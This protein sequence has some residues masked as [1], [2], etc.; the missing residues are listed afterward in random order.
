M[1]DGVGSTAFA[2]TDGGQLASEDGP[3]DSDKISYS[4]LNRTRSSLNLQQPYA[5]DW[6]QSYDYDNQWR[7][8]DVTSPAGTFTYNYI[9]SYNDPYTYAS[10]LVYYLAMPGGSHTDKA[11]DS[12]GRLTNSALLSG[13]TILDS[14]AYAYNGGNQRTRQVFTAGNYTD[15]GYDN[16]G[17]L[18]SAK[19]TESDTTTARLNEQFGY[20]Y[21][22]AWNLNVR[23]NNA[24]IQNFAV[25]S[26][27]ELSNSFRSGTLTV[28]GSI[29]E[30]LAPD[31][32]SYGVTNVTVNGS[33]A[34]LYAD[35]TF[36]KTGFTP[37]DG[38]NTYTAVA[39]DTTG[40]QDTDVIT[41][42]LPATNTFTYDARG[43]L[44]SDGHR[45]F[46]Y[47]D[48]NQL[49]SV[50]VSNAY[51]SEFTYDGFL[52]KR[53]LKDFGWFAGAWVET[54][55]VRFV[56]DGRLVVQERDADNL[57]HVSY[58]TGSDLSG[59]REGAGGIG[60]LLARTDNR[61][62]ALGTTDGS[63][64]YGFD[65]N[66]NVTA[67]ATTNGTVAAKYSY[68][69]FGNTLS[70]TGPLSEA[71]KYRFSTKEIHM[72]SGLLHFQY[73][74]FD[75][76]LQKWLSRDPI[77][78]RGGINLFASFK[79]DP[80]DLLDPL[81]LQPGVPPR[82]PTEECD[83]EREGMPM[84]GVVVRRPLDLGPARGGRPRSRPPSEDREPV[85]LPII[86]NNPL[87]EA[88]GKLFELHVSLQEAEE[89]IDFQR[90][91]QGCHTANGPGGTFQMSYVPPPPPVLI[92]SGGASPAPVYP[93]SRNAP[94]P[95]SLPIGL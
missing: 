36:A 90:E 4:Y 19:G 24:L 46:T 61:L 8:A 63:A 53:V 44:T 71:N 56:Y 48:E 80:L 74:M 54:N 16:I 41:A 20:G 59:A 95:A 28:A 30:A 26:L 10:D 66:G 33:T 23:T 79:N 55:E 21:D 87:F 27:N 52:R 38:S 31:P 64:V 2:W 22:A 51:R 72:N 69:P 86:A 12:L 82:L 3:W 83:L 18:I 58:T 29:S 1:I 7:L 15:Y 76:S 81:G 75:P 37:A 78:E 45:F 32:Y 67:M 34:N 6:V 43:N 92:M 42:Y 77:Q 47:D 57:P 35:R 5:S 91:N 40:R 17:Q 65:G 60:G 13:S 25:N 14:H 39:R 62:L 50:T 85:R 84:S 9:S 93:V 94:P 73:R 49:I 89:Q 68:D 70:K 11:F 88:A